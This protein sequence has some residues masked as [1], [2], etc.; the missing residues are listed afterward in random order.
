M[1]TLLSKK[2]CY[3]VVDEEGITTLPRLLSNQILVWQV[4]LHNMVAHRG[5]RLN[6]FVREGGDEPNQVHHDHKADF[7]HTVSGFYAPIAQ[8]AEQRTFNA[9]VLGSIPSGR[10]KVFPHGLIL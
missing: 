4:M 5:V 2:C 6:C 1:G 10:T 8:L 7:P 3:E 9:W